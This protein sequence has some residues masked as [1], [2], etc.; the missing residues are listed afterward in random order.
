MATKL[1][2]SRAFASA[3]RPAKPS[4]PSRGDQAVRCIASTASRNVAMPKD[5]QNMR[6]APR[7]HP[8]VLK[9][10]LVNP[11][12]K[13]GSKADDLHRYGS[14]LMGCMPKYIQQFSVWKDELVIYIPPS[15]VIPVFSFLKYNTAA[16]FTQVS[17]ITAVDFP[18]KDQRFE[19]V[20]NLLSVR[21]NARIR[22]KT[23]AD[24]ATPVPSITPLYDGAN[25]YER[26]VYD[27]FGVFFV[28]H[29]DLRRI[30]TDYGFEGHP[31]RKDFP[32]T[33]YTELRYDEEKK[34]VVTEPLEMTQAFRNFEGGSS[35]WEQVGPGQDRKPDTFKLPTPKPEE[36]KD[37]PKK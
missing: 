5:A 13:Y 8:K 29:P 12:D 4:L 30:M 34:R 37:E 35:A 36:K 22:V 28:N 31:L 2:R 18:T 11:A 14:W 10:P 21:H 16:E 25:W 27:M 26:E 23:Y 3:L 17:T 7:D 15:G 32:L 6:T 1:C 20:Y 9:A 33:G 24:E 19:I